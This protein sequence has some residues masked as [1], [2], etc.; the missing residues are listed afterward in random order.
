MG[1]GEERKTEHTEHERSKAEAFEA[2]RRKHEVTL[3]LRMKTGV[4]HA[5]HC[6]SAGNRPGIPDLGDAFLAT[7]NNARREMPIPRTVLIQGGHAARIAANR[8][9]PFHRLRGPAVDTLN[10]AR[11]WNAE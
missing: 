3:E 10:G 2:N 9:T 5:R 1:R 11:T 4:E 6:R 7:M 8:N